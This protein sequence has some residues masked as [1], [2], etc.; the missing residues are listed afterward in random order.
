M[1]LLGLSYE[2]VLITVE[3]IKFVGANFGRLLKFYGGHKFVCFL[4]TTK[5]NMTSSWRMLIS[6]KEVTT[7]STKIEP[8]WNLMIPQYMYINYKYWKNDFFTIVKAVLVFT[9]KTMYITRLK[10]SQGEQQL[11]QMHQ[12][13]IKVYYCPSKGPVAI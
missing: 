7:N 8:P 2:H 9:I 12:K 5:E 6:G 10:N 3:S 4:I 11:I 1:I 13:L